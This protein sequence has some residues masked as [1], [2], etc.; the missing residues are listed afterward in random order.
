MIEGEWGWDWSGAEGEGKH[1][2]SALRARCGVRSELAMGR[3]E[4]SE[5]GWACL[6]VDFR[7]SGADRKKAPRVGGPAVFGSVHED[8]NV[9]PEVYPGKARTNADEGPEPAGPAAERNRRRQR[10]ACC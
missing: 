8:G 9:T 5:R 4:R 10:E 6:N 3:W 7:P 2:R 1:A